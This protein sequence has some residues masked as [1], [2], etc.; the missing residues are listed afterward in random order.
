[1]SNTTTASALFIRNVAEYLNNP[2]KLAE[3]DKLNSEESN[4]DVCHSHDFCDAN[5]FML[6][7]VNATLGL[8]DDEY[9]SDNQEQNDLFNAAWSEAK[10]I[11]F[12]TGINA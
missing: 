2:E 7:A 9:D 6:A 5:V 10:R 12:S 8:P 4:P 1:M 11:G 3:I